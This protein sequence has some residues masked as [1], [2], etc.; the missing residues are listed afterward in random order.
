MP[1]L[2]Q[3]RRHRACDQG[4]LIP[5]GDLAGDCLVLRC[6]HPP[7]GGIRMHRRVAS[8]IALLL[9]LTGMT[10]VSL[11]A[12]SSGAAQAKDVDCSDFAN[13][14][15]AQSYFL[16]HGGPNSDPDGL[17]ADGDGI[18][19]ESNPCP[20]TTGGG[21]GAGGGGHPTTHKP[22]HKFTV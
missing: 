3:Q 18:A 21:G 19:C 5:I 7:R 9:T 20:C 10:F 14:A 22:P 4:Q 17:D 1:R 13:Q 2:C 15:S 11:T 8:L 16:N 12:V 6:R